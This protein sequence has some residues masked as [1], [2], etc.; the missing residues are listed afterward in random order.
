M[1]KIDYA[2]YLIEYLQEIGSSKSNGFGMMPIEWA[3]IHGWSK[4]VGGPLSMWESLTIMSMSKAFVDQYTTSNGKVVPPP[5]Q[6]A[7]FDKNVTSQRIGDVLRG[8]A[9]RRKTKK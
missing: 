2:E 5:Y 4:T 1:P 9:R 7:S 6:S 8:I 3:D